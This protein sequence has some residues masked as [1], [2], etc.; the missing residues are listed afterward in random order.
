MSFTP[1]VK[2]TTYILRFYG[3]LN[4]NEVNYV[5]KQFINI[6]YVLLKVGHSFVNYTEEQEI[7]INEVQILLYPA[8]HAG[9]R[10]CRQLMPCGHQHLPGPSVNCLHQFTF[11]IKVVP[12]IFWVFFLIIDKKLVLLG[13]PSFIKQIPSFIVNIKK[14]PHFLPKKIVNIFFIYDLVTSGHQRGCKHWFDH[15]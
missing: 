3:I 14:F 8:A 6:H 15:E 9:G 1:S 4:K 12:N 11:A 13:I 10:F 7:R 5:S 2:E